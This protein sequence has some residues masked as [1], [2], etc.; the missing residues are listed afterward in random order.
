MSEIDYA[1]YGPIASPENVMM[2]R[3]EM[4]EMR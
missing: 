4:D 3:E 1:Y 2:R